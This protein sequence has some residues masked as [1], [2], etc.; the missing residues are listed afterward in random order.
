MTGPHAAPISAYGL[1]MSDAAVCVA[2]YLRPGTELCQARRCTCDG[3]KVDI[4][5]G[6]ALC[7]VSTS[8]AELSAITTSTT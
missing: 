6:L 2:R 5:A 1:R 8:Q 7:H 4:R 3:V